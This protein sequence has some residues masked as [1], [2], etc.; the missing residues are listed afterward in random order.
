MICVDIR[1]TFP[2]KL[3]Y[4]DSL[5]AVKEKMKVLFFPDST[6]YAQEHHF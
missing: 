3:N 4:L 6:K 2:P 5:K 1:L